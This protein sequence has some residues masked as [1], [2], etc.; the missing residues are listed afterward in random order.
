V[1]STRG[2]TWRQKPLELAASELPAL[3]AKLKQI[4]LVTMDDF[5]KIK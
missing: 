4:L 2:K 3:A 5:L 1:R